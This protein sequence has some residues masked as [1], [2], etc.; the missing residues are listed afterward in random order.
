MK[1]LYFSQVLGINII[2]QSLHCGLLHG[3]NYKIYMEKKYINNY[4]EE[5]ENTSIP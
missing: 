1:Y 5:P 2:E 3:Y 4:E